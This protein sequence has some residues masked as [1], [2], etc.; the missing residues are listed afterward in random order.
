MALQPA[1]VVLPF[2]NGSVEEG[3]VK[4]GC[5]LDVRPVAD[6]TQEMP[7]PAVNTIQVKSDAAS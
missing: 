7:Y 4:F 1:L 6:F 2:Y 5:L 3:K